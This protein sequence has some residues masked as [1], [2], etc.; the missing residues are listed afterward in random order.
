MNRAELQVLRKTIKLVS[1]HNKHLWWE[2]KR[3]IFDSGFQNYYPRQSEY[4][5]PARKAI[6]NLS[7]D[8]IN[9]L[10]G[11]YIRRHADDVSP[12]VDK[13]SSYYTHIVIEEI[14][15]RAG[16]AAYRTENW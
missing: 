14:V 12:S 5:L 15:R 3:Q 11:T 9:V 6:L 16:L 8:A 2:L 13:V 1:H 10:C 4:E 7:Q